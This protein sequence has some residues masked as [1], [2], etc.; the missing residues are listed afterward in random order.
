MKTYTAL[1]LLCLTG[2]GLPAQT[3]LSLDSCIRVALKNRASIKALSQDQLLAALK[4]ADL[5]AKYWPQVSLNYNY[6]Y[7]P[8]IQTSIVPVGQF[9]QP[10]TD[11]VR[12]IRFGTPWQQNAG[13]T[14]YQPLWDASIASQV[15]ESKIQDRLKQLDRENAENELRYEVVKTYANI[16]LNQTRITDSALDT[17]RSFQSVQLM[18]ARLEEGRLLKTEYNKA[19]VNHNHALEN[20]Q[21]AV[22]EFVKQIVYLS[23]LTTLPVE[24]L[25]RANYQSESLQ[26]LLHKADKTD[27]NPQRISAINQLQGQNELVQQQ[28]ISERRKNKP[29]VGLDGFFGANQ[30]TNAFNPVAKNSWYLAS[31]VGLAVK[32]NLLAGENRANHLQQLSVQATSLKLQVEEQEQ[33]VR[34]D[35]LE[36]DETIRTQQQ[37]LIPIEENIALFKESLQIYQERFSAGKLEAND[38]N[39]MEIDL[40]KEI[41]KQQDTKIQLLQNQLKRLFTS[42]N[43]AVL[44]R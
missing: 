35:L 8:I 28:L 17:L 34:K 21:L 31:Y 37:Q 25:L 13:A 29:T 22:T 39:S 30:F 33:L 18:K 43:L 20:Y 32:W 1:F 9:F 14:V 36:L 7:N 26:S 19:R 5:R 6:R 12:A 27:L 23:Y 15:A 44:L 38:L 10:A 16:W 24:Q 11:E 40:Q 42:G 3:P 2:F 41:L 4:T